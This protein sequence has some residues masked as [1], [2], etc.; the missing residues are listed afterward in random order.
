MSLFSFSLHQFEGSTPSFLRIL[1]FPFFNEV[2]QRLQC[3]AS[4]PDKDVP[5]V[6]EAAHSDMNQGTSGTNYH[7]L[8]MF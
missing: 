1:S 3:I 6:S 4:F 2:Y 5:L 8:S 7:H